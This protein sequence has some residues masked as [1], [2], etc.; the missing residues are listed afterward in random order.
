MEGKFIEP[1][2]LVSFSKIDCSKDSWNSYR[3]KLFCFPL[4]IHF[5][6]K[7]YVSPNVSTI[8]L[9]K[10]ENTS[11]RRSSAVVHRKF[12]NILVPVSLPV[13]AVAVVHPSVHPT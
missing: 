10:Q 3:V 13:R 2:R 4:N 11:P 5:P 9:C 8:I 6:I 1:H 7:L 12:R